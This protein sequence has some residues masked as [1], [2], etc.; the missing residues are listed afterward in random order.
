N[1]AQRPG[2]LLRGPQS[3]DKLSAAS[4]A[5]FWVIIRTTSSALSTACIHQD[6]MMS[7]KPAVRKRGLGLGVNCSDTRSRVNG[8]QRWRWR[9]QEDPHF[10]EALQDHLL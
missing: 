8:E 2:L 4:A 6:S 9:R 1:T 5:T 10:D 7:L 3:P